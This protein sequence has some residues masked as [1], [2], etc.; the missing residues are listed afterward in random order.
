MPKRKAGSAAAAEDE[1]AVAAVATCT[2]CLSDL[3]ASSV[4]SALLRNCG[5]TVCADCFAILAASDKKECP[6]CRKPIS[7]LPPSRNFAYEAV[8]DVLPPPPAKKRVTAAQ[9]GLPAAPESLS[10]QLLEAQAQFAEGI[11]KAKEK[12]MARMKAEMDSALERYHELDRSVQT[13]KKQFKE[14]RDQLRGLRKARYETD[15]IRITL[16][17]TLVPLPGGRVYLF[18]KPKVKNGDSVNRKTLAEPPP[19]FDNDSEDSEVAKD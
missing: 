3:R 19:R 6:L 4:T 1:S 17:T 16:L 14:A 5:H 10:K 15:R 18:C 8:L 2:V 13:A 11:K 9:R 7:S 12:D